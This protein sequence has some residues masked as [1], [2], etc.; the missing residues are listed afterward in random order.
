[1]ALVA[2]GRLLTAQSGQHARNPHTK[3]GSALPRTATFRA[4][5]DS[6][7]QD[8]QTATTPAPKP[9]QVLPR[10]PNGPAHLNGNL[11]RIQPSDEAAIRRAITLVQGKWGIAILCHLQ[12]GPVRVGELKRR[13]RPISKKVLNQHLRRL[14]GDGLI[15]RTEI[16]GKIPHIEYALTNPLGYSVLCLLQLIA[17]WGSQVLVGTPDHEACIRRYEAVESINISNGAMSR[18]S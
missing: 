2:A 4:R 16:K 1:M 5:R 11:P 14:E 8:R 13:L 6:S 10:R 7:R 18:S 9:I 15:V 17:L 3:G 12:G